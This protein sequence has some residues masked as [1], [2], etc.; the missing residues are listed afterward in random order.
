MFW[1]GLLPGAIGS[2][3]CHEAAGILRGL[4]GLSPS[5]FALAELA[6]LK[7]ETSHQEYYAR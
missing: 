5:L 3:Q 4:G 1:H 7:E 2:D 6:P